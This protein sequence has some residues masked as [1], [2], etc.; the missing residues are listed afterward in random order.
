VSV[1]WRAGRESGGL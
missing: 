1:N